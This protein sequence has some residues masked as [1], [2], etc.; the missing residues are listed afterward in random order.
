MKSLSLRPYP[1]KVIVFSSL[2]ELR[3]YY[4]KLTGEKFPFRTEKSGGQ[5]IKMVHD[6]ELAKNTKW[7]VY[8]KKPHVLAHEFSHVL[9]KVFEMIGAEPGCGNGEPFCY[10][11]S[12]LML[13]AK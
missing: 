4:E 12:Q 6:S 5:F 3:K 8:G 7:L 2:K 10:M 1:G 13:E 11:L 9:L